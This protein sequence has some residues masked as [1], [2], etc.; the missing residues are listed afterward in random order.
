MKKLQIYAKFIDVLAHVCS[1]SS[2]DSKLFWPWHPVYVKIPHSRE[3]FLKYQRFSG[4]CLQFLR[5]GLIIQKAVEM[6]MS[7]KK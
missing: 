2:S 5:C 1:Q 7:D 3:S 6:V 4:G